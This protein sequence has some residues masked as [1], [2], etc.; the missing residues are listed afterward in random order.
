MAKSTANGVSTTY[1]LYFLPILVLLLL[2]LV[3]HCKVTLIF[4]EELY[5]CVEYLSDG[6]FILHSATIFKENLRR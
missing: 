2:V 4:V 1:L 3:R 6:F 5:F